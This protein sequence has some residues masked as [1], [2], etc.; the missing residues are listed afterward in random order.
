[1]E[2]CLIEFPDGRVLCVSI[3]S[4]YAALFLDKLRQEDPV[5]A[6]QLAPAMKLCEL[7]GSL[8]QLTEKTP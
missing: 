4:A 2:K 8:G 3:S 6:A 5:A 1:M 7:L